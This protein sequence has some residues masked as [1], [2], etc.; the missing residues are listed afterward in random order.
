MSVLAADAIALGR[1]SGPAKTGRGL[2]A[3]AAIRYK[4]ASRVP[5]P[6]IASLV[7]A[8]ALNSFS[9]G[10]R[11]ERWRGRPKAIGSP[12]QN[13]R[14]QAGTAL[15]WRRAAP[16]DPVASRWCARGFGAN[17]PARI[18]CKPPGVP[19]GRA[20]RCG[21]PSVPAPSRAIVL[22]TACSRQGHRRSMPFEIW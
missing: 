5:A 9:G 8:E 15:R 14:G 6:L 12:G 18:A 16:R 3:K 19:C 20:G 7:A 21:R 11:L 13:D 1:S 4:E 17:A 10:R 2:R 22:I